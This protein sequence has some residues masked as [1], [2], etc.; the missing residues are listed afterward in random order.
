MARSL[1]LT[2]RN[3]LATSVG[4]L[5]G[6][7]R[8]S[9]RRP[10][11]AT[12]VSRDSRS[13]VPPPCPAGWNT[14]PPSF[15]G[16]GAQKAGTTWWFRLIE[17]HP[18]VYSGE[19]LDPE[20]HFFDRF[21]DTW[22]SQA[23]IEAY[24]KFFPRPSGGQAGEKTPEYLRCY[25]VPE[26]LHDAAPDARLIVM[27]RDPVERY[28]SGRSHGAHRLARAG[29]TSR[30]MTEEMPWVVDAFD[31]GLYAAQLERV[32]RWF[33]LE[34]LLVLQYEA[35]VLRPADELARTYAF[36]RLSPHTL[37]EPELTRPRNRTHGTKVGLEPSRRQA[38]VQ[39]YESDVRR[40]SAMVPSFDPSLWPNFRG[41]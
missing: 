30:T 1:K 14:G 31:R 28:I 33:P 19:G 22:P 10:I 3:R 18:D 20:L 39:L 36:L 16:I 29:A 6:Q 25:W 8:N 9:Q 37:D 40:L 12:S 38:L 32:L 13:P 26:M 41:L 11:S 35:C 2:R 21:Q 5:V 24:H 15:I 34:Q 7:R 27:L 17:S 4:R 23:D